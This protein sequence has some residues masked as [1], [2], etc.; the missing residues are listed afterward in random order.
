[1]KCVQNMDIY[2]N[3]PTYNKIGRYIWR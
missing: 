3:I 1:M 2:C